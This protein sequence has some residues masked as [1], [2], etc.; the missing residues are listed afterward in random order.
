LPIW[1]KIVRKL[2][3][4]KNAPLLSTPPS[5]IAESVNPK[6]GMKDATGIT[7]YFLQGTE[8][9]EEKSS[10]EYIK[11]DGRYRTIFSH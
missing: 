3:P 2:N 10:L 9:T 11:H 5:I 7:M 6:L 4:Q 1:D 8:P